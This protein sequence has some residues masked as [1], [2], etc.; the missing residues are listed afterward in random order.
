M[1]RDGVVHVQVPDPAQP[2]RWFI[3][4]L[5]CTGCAEQMEIKH[6]QAKQAQWWINIFAY[7]HTQ[8][9]C[10]FDPHSPDLQ[11]EERLQDS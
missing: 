5:R 11:T 10:G 3:I 7:K 1:L 9:R 8:S 6:V 4:S 2:G